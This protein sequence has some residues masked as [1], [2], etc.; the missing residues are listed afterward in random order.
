MKK[1]ISTCILTLSACGVLSA[2]LAN[3]TSLV[4]SVMDSAG[5]S[6]AGVAIVATNTGTQETYKATTNSQGDYTIPFV[7]VG[8]YNITASQSG[9]ETLVKDGVTVNY[10]QTV[11]TDFTLQVGTISQKV[12]VTAS[13][14]PL[15]T[16]DASVREV[17]GER[18]V[19][20]LPLNGRDPLQLA[21]TAPGVL[22]GQKSANGIPPGEDFIGAGTR[23][24]QNSVSLDGIAIMNN[25]ITTVPYHPSPDAIQEFE[26]RPGPIRPNMAAIWEPI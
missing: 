25:L 11:R 1:L 18:S 9:F 24:I 3:T 5:A 15:A 12:V 21:T 16:D 13:A 2:Q 20:E 23:E 8:Q 14:P 22:P 10:N 6:M 4:G 7:R 26:C 17:I 19:A